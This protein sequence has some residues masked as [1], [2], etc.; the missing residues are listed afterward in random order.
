MAEEEKTD[1]DFENETDFIV[2][3]DVKAHSENTKNT[4]ALLVKK[5]RSNLESERLK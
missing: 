5:K 3:E 4:L 2:V 1:A